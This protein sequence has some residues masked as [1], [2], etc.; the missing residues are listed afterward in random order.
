MR[1]ESSEAS[2]GLLDVD[3]AYV[4]HLVQNGRLEKVRA[5]LAQVRPAKVV[6][7]VHNPGSSLPPAADIVEAYRFIFRHAQEKGYDAVLVL[8]DDFTWGRV[9]AD[10]GAAVTTFLKKNAHRSLVYH[11]GCL[12]VAMFPVG[13]RTYLTLGCGTHAS[14][15]TRPCR[16]RVLRYDKKI[17]D[18]DMFLFFHFWRYAYGRPLCYQLYGRTA[19][20]DQWLNFCGLTPLLRLG[21]R[22]LMLDRRAE[23]GYWIC[24]TG[25]KSV[26]LAGVAVMVAVV[27]WG[28]RL[29]R[30]VKKH[31]PY[32]PN[33]NPNP[34]VKS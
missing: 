21:S 4:L 2:D 19:N 10:D 20:S 12:P 33:P 6:H 15:Y 31:I 5:Q 22:L 7:L 11:L 13:D 26:P 8:E 16:E 28:P 23:P 3:A 17:R 25:A 32:N 30:F 14:V 1:L 27:V 29:L 34:R 9:S 18:W 24:Y